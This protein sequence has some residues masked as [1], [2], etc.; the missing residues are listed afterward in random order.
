MSQ[1]A[2]T[3]LVGLA[4][5]DD[6]VGVAGAI[7]AQRSRGDRVVV[8]WLSAGEMTEA[9]GP[10]PIEEVAE[11]R[12]EH[13][14]RAGEILGVETRFLGFQDTHISATRE[15]VAQVARLICE[16]HPTGLLTWGHAWSRGMRHPDHQACG[17]IFRDAVTMARIAKVVAPLE[18][19][20][21]AVPVFTLRDVHSPL[22]AVAV[23]VEE[24]RETIHELARFYR[25]RVGFGDREWLDQRL[26]R[27]GEGWGRRYA[28]EFDAWETQPGLV[29]ALLPAAPLENVIHPERGARGGG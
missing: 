21:L 5:P 26:R 18:P 12:R 1:P 2:E 13:G 20:R 6:E 8:V 17:Q 28:E 3:L 19:H 22:P 25:E 24:H 7:L 11:R 23:D 27:V 4:H 14:R 15:A 29:D 16:V 10:I 9:F